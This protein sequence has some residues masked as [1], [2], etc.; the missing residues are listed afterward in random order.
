M[1]RNGEEL[2][3]YI[4]EE[5]LSQHGM[6]Q[7]D[8]QKELAIAMYHAL[9][10]NHVALCGTG[11][12]QGKIQAYI[13]ALVVSRLSAQ[14]TG[15]A[16]IVT[17]TLA[18]Q[19]SLAENEIPQISA[20]LME[21]RITDHPQMSAVRKGKQHY[22][23]DYR[24]AEYRRSVEQNAGKADGDMLREL[25]RLQRQGCCAADLDRA[26]LRSYVKKRINVTGCSPSCPMSPGCRYKELNRRYLSGYYDFQI[27]NQNYFLADLIRQRRGGTS[28]FP[29]CHAVVLDEAHGLVETAR[30]MY[31][32]TL[33]V[34]KLDMRDSARIRRLTKQCTGGKNAGQAYST[35]EHYGR[36]LYDRLMRGWQNAEENASAVRQ[37]KTSELTLGR[38]ERFC[39]RQMQSALADLITGSRKCGAKERDAKQLERV[40]REFSEKLEVFR[41]GD[42]YVCRMEWQ[43][44]GT[45]VLAAV[46]EAPDRLLYQDLW[47][48]HVAVIVTADTLY[49]CSDFQR[50]R[51][52]TGLNHV[53]A[54]RVTEVICPPVCD[55]QHQALLY[56]SERVPFPD[57]Q[58]AGYVQAVAGEIV[59]LAETFD[60]RSVVFF[61]S[62]RLMEL[63]SVRLQEKNA[64]YPLFLKEKGCADV[65]GAFWRSEKGILFA[66]GDTWRGENPAEG[67]L[68]GLIVVRL[69][70]PV[71]DLSPDYQ[72]KQYE[73]PET[74]Q[75]EVIVPKMLMRL[76]QWMEKG[77]C[78]ENRALVY[79][80]LDARAALGGRYRSAILESLPTMLVTDQIGDV[81]EFITE[82]KPESH[83]KKIRDNICGGNESISDRPGSI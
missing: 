6:G 28:V 59:R 50:F 80:I 72:R 23:C 8:G 10:K 15:P 54:G 35:L 3:A 74:Y 57:I 58:N 51:Q 77:A 73:D 78:G 46:L 64:G 83:M 24:L 38:M 70:F 27:A 42:G 36:Q 4:Y 49:G 12:G 29:S 26:K 63:V 41:A 40:C 61:T 82:T 32:V 81:K 76:R 30:Q 52:L 17:S 68:R 21:H 5:I 47:K 7:H 66:C 69:P 14:K 65:T 60:G 56:I 75:K 9:R 55:Y 39:I 71:P 2:L 34:Q 44:N 37:G 11:A 19:R 45:I 1:E 20:I 13:L 18:Q 33:D 67:I 25:D 43:K 53:A 62:Y 79:A 48:H 31:R 22:V 16:L